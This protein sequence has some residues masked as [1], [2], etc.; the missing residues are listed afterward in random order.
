MMD[1]NLKFDAV[2]FLYSNIV[3]LYSNILFFIFLRFHCIYLVGRTEG[4]RGLYKGEER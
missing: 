2:T 4:I 3:I 1:F